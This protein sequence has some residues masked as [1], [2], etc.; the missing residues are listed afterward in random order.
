MKKKKLPN[1][2]NFG[3]LHDSYSSY[4][5]YDPQNF[6]FHFEKLDTSKFPD[7]EKSTKGMGE[8]KQNKV[9]QLLTKYKD[10]INEIEDAMLEFVQFQIVQDPQ[11]TIARTKDVKTDIEYFTA[12][13]FFPL[14]GG[15]KKEV[16][17]YVGKAQEY[18][19]DTKD[20]LA[21]NVAYVKM[22][23]TLRRR[24]DEGSL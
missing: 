20:K 7:Y 15:K 6:F 12:K 9:L 8:Q 24:L 14:K 10:E 2:L 13:T 22:K 1:I 3:D 16:K 17:I 11:V 5:L 4:E 23:S 19:N 18:G 21:L